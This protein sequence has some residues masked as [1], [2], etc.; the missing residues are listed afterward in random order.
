VVTAINGAGTGVS[1]AAVQVSPGQY[2][3]QLTAKTSGVAN[4]VSVA[5]DAFTGI[6]T[7][8]STAVASDA[9]I[10]IGS[11]PGAYSVT[12]S[13]NQVSSVLPGVTLSLKSTGAAT[14]TISQDAEKLADSVK[15][16]VDALN[17]V[18]DEIKSLTSFD[19]QAVK[20]SLLLGNFTLRT[21]QSK[22]VSSVISQVSVSALT[23]GANAGVS[24]TSS[25]SYTFD[26]AKFLE[27]YADD[28]DAVAALFTR[29]G[30]SAGAP[31]GTS[32][33][34]QGSSDRTR[35]GTYSVT[36]DAA[37]EK[38]ERVGTQVGGGPITLAETI[39]V[40]VGTTS[41][42]HVAGAGDTFSEIA[43]A[44]NLKLAASSLGVEATV[45]GGALVLR[46][47]GYGTGATFTVESDRA[48]VGSTGIANAIGVPLTDTGVN[49][50]GK[51]NGVA[52]TGIG[53]FLVAGA[54]DDDVAG[55]SLKIDATP[56]DVPGLNTSFG[57]FTYVLGIGQRVASAANDSIDAVSGSITAAIQGRQTEITRLEA[58]IVEWDTR[59]E[60]RQVDLRKKFAAME[61]ALGQ[62]QAQSN[63]LAGQVASLNASFGSRR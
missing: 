11:G 46:S 17:P 19:T 58:Q 21:L 16:M 61:R 10:T 62:A 26:R 4:D 5:A 33:S 50:A 57:T 24:V 37:P 35:A 54:D 39:E 6:G 14:V 63:W 7:L 28:P 3:L 41:I 44:L 20:G 34:L 60:K 31:A 8:A 36:L 48:G 51:I 23:S 38:A 53:Q 1:A 52:A 49:V 40:T 59:L 55:L 42:T 45:E 9:S 27:A 22:I 32:V 30:T 2:K 25:G 43:D 15:A 18:V 29:G 12:S 56:A 47:T 13:T